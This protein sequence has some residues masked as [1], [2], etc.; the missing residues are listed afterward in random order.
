[1][2]SKKMSKQQ[3]WILFTQCRV[4]LRNT[5]LNYDTAYEL[6]ARAK[7]DPASVRDQL[8]KLPGAIVKD[9]PT[10]AEM[11]KPTFKQGVFLR[12]ELG[13]DIRPA[14]LTRQQVTEAIG[15]LKENGTKRTR[16]TVS[17]SLT[18]AGAI[19]NPFPKKAA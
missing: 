17:K 4:D 5:N 9:M 6:V 16:T 10:N 11:T 14:N 3:S 2:A 8:S 15:K 7:V 1:M 18:A 19:Q 12:R 13:L